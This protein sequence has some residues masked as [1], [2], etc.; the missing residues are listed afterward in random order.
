VLPS[1]I[2]ATVKTPAS[3]SALGIFSGNSDSHKQAFDKFIEHCSLTLSELPARYSWLAE[4]LRTILRLVESV[5]RGD[6]YDEISDL[7]YDEKVIE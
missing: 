7:L 4:P 5:S 3:A 2:S 6:D 1:V